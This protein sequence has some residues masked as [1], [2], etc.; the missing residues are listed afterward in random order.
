MN[1]NYLAVRDLPQHTMI[2]TREAK[3][4][5]GGREMKFSLRSDKFSYHP[6]SVPSRDAKFVSHEIKSRHSL[7]LK[8]G[9]PSILCDDS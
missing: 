6:L 3:Q 2:S 9:I 5:V 8:I 7:Q 4:Q 1:D